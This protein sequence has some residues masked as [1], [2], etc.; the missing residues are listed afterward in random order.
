MENGARNQATKE[1]KEFIFSQ[2]NV[3]LLSGILETE[4]RFA[5][6]RNGEKFYR[7]VVTCKRDDGKK[8]YIPII[9]SEKIHLAILEENIGVKILGKLRNT[10]TCI[11]GSQ[12]NS[13]EV[14]VVNLTAFN[15]EI[16]KQDLNFAHLSGNI[17][18]KPDYITAR[19]QV[20]NT[21]VRMNNKEKIPCVAWRQT[22]TK[23]ANYEKRDYLEALGKLENRAYTIVDEV[24]V[25]RIC[26]FCVEKFI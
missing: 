5:Y 12:E 22:A 18:K 2:Q 13:I 11:N 24:I 15:N 9:L 7:N 21:M 3:V 6:E 20:T 23:F 1:E 26:R 19:L 10:K 8:N 16:V 4:F 14:E 25:E 17:L